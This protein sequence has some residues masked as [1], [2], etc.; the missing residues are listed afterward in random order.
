MAR[1]ERASHWEN[2]SAWHQHPM[3]VS[4]GDSSAV[5]R[6]VSSLTSSPDR[7]SRIVTQIESYLDELSPRRAHVRLIFSSGLGVFLDGYD[8][9]MMAVA[10]VFIAP[11]WRLT[12]A[13]LGLLAASTLL[14]AMLGGAIG[15]RCADLYGRKWLYLIDIGTFLIAALLS[16]VAWN[17]ASLFIFRM[18][19]GIGIG[20]DYPLSATF[21]AEFAPRKRRGAMMTW[22]F[23]FFFYAGS[24]AAM[25]V[26]FMLAHFGPDAWRFLFA[27]GAV[28]ALGLLILRRTLPESPRWLL[29]KRSPEQALAALRQ[30]HPDGAPGRTRGGEALGAAPEAHATGR[31][32]ELFTRPYLRRTA[33]ITLP[34]FLMDMV[35]YGFSI[36][37]PTL[38]LA[39]GMRSFGGSILLSATL[40]SLG[41]IGF[42]FVAGRI[43]RSGRI[44]AQSM[45][46]LAL[47][48]GMAALGLIA[49][50][51]TTA[52]FPI[53][54]C[55]LF[56]K[57]ANAFP[58]STS[59]V[60]PVE[61]FPTELRASAHGLAT[62][63]SRIGAATSV[64]LF[65]ILQRA[66]GIGPL[67]LVIAAAQLAASFMTLLTGEE[68]AGRSLEEITHGVRLKPTAQTVTSA[69]ELSAPLVPEK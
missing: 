49:M 47:A 34:W 50:S 20:V 51:G 7:S 38:L 37:I 45:G 32:R 57:L 5:F 59:G 9:A 55:I 14:G 36:Y 6:T 15:G 62:S 8:S 67:L 43:E 66:W 56:V 18:L 29:R 19:V 30:F 26:G 40:S 11:A 58:D 39:F 44:R 17:F 13:A 24:V 61:L 4:A 3:R 23:G 46:F 48:A 31:W 65:P 60:L 12:P 53:A 42:L 22:S 33:L 25:L 21:L 54:A 27:S 10:I 63:F 28:P 68:P 35:D 1:G 64:F 2:A 41:T 52:I 16:A 69:Q